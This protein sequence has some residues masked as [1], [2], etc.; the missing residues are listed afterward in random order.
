MFAN[1]NLTYPI[2]TLLSTGK[3][4]FQNMGRLIQKS[5]DT[6]ARLLQ[7]A[8]YNIA[9][10]QYISQRMFSSS[11]KL[12]LVIDDTLLKK[13]HSRFMQGSGGFFDTK[14]GRRIMAYR[15]CIALISDGRFAIPIGCRYLFAKELLDRINHNF[16]SKNDIAKMFVETAK[17]LF[18]HRIIMV[19]ADGLYATAE[20]IR[21]CKNQNIN[22]EVRM[23]SNRVVNYK[24]K[25]MALK[26][27]VSKLAIKPTGRQTARTITAIWHEIELEISIVRRIDK[28]GDETIVFQ[29]ATYKGLPKIHVASY[30]ARWVIE[31]MIGTSKQHLGIQDCYSCSLKK[32]HNHVSS[33]LLAYALTQLVMKKQKIKIPEDAVRYLKARNVNSLIDYFSRLNQ[34]FGVIND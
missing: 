19:V 30:K 11:K 25:K 12:Y 6:V 16:P 3:K 15:L 13:I 31:K 2:L 26:E 29:A 34:I 20:F 28:H 22:L 7:P 17:N 9:Q 5:G 8:E 33:S 23:H 18:P 4:S 1:T 24:R 27:I 10:A 32:Q 21:W 14:I